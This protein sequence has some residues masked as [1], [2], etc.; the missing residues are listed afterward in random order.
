MPGNRNFMFR[1]LIVMRRPSLLF[2]GVVVV[3]LAT[4]A[5]ADQVSREHPVSV[6][7]RGGHTTYYNSKAFELAGVTKNTRDSA[8]GTYD[9]DPNGEFN[10][11]VTDRARNVFLNVGMR[12]T[13][14]AEQS[15]IR[16]RDALAFISKQF[17]RF[18]LTS[19][20]HESG[21]LRALQEVRTRCDLL[22]RVSYEAE[23]PELEAMLSW[24]RKAA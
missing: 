15:L 12:P 9:R 18:G 24:L 20:C 2:A 21:N 4:P 16:N 1:D 10:G 3:G 8:A 23:G 5:M 11:R 22:H 6:R 13:F 19:V 7:H 17:V 14:T